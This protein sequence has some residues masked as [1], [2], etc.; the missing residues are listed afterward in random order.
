MTDMTPINEETV[1]PFPD[2]IEDARTRPSI[3][4]KRRVRNKDK[5]PVELVLQDGTN[6]TGHM[7]V[8]L[9]ER[10]LDCLNDSRP[11]MPFLAEDGAML[12]LS[13]QTVAV[14]RPLEG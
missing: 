10:V 3:A 5:M 6:L 7:F 8:G 2:I 1:T 11:F 12:L 14:C 9:G 13:K 4:P